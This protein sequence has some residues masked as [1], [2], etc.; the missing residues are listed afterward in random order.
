MKLPKWRVLFSSWKTESWH[1]KEWSGLQDFCP[2]ETIQEAL[3]SMFITLVF[4][5]KGLLGIWVYINERIQEGHV[6]SSSFQNSALRSQAGG[7]GPSEVCL[8][9]LSTFSDIQWRSFPF[10][11]RTVCWL[12]LSSLSASNGWFRWAM[13]FSG[14]AS[15][16][17]QTCKF[18]WE[19][20]LLHGGMP[21][22]LIYRQVNN[23]MVKWAECSLR[24]IE[25]LEAHN[26]MEGNIGKWQAI[27]W[28]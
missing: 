24:D 21:L 25:D 11:R 4:L 8:Q 6:L 17:Y 1:N 26:D 2:L 12:L 28:A 7:A 9:P 18:G 10:R 20:S 27:L 14:G 16:M 5:L 15:P 23:K 3:E 19:H 22:A 13:D